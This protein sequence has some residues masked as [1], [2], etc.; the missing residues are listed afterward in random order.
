MYPAKKWKIGLFGG[1]FNPPHM[2][3]TLLAQFAIKQ[4]KLDLLIF[5]PSFKSVDKVEQE[6]LE[7]EKRAYMLSLSKTKY[8]SVISNFEL[9]LRKP[10]ESV[11][12]VRH[13]K[14]RFP[15]D[16]LYFLLG[17]D[18]CATLNGW[19]GIEE[20][21]QLTTPVIFKRK[22]SSTELDSLKHLDRKLLEKVIF[23]PNRFFPHSSTAVREQKKYSL[24]HKK[25][26][27]YLKSQ[28]S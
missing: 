19:D 11:V 23:L 20:I 24:L 26:K 3:H 10:V 18:H 21:F 22:G 6:Y 15:E 9:N 12:T 1:S 27:S 25:V 17:S 28:L 16:E 4:L 7:G 13:F 2:A 14:E 5:I 8:L